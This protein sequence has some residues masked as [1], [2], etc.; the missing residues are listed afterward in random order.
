MRRLTFIVLLMVTGS[1]GAVEESLI[2]SSGTQITE[3]LNS[4]PGQTHPRQVLFAGTGSVEVEDKFF[5]GGCNYSDM[6]YKH[7]SKV[8]VTLKL[9]HPGSKY[10]T[11]GNYEY[12]IPLL[13][14]VW[15]LS[16]QSA[17]PSKSF[18]TS[19]TVV[20]K[21][22]NATNINQLVSSFVVNDYYKVRVTRNGSATSLSQLQTDGVKLEISTK[23]VTNRSYK[24]DNF[25][26]QG[27]YTY[28]SD[29][30][31][32]AN[33]R[34]DVARIAI[35]LDPSY[36]PLVQI[37]GFNSAITTSNVTADEYDLE[38]CFLDKEGQLVPNSNWSTDNTSLVNFNF[39]NLNLKYTRVTL[40]PNNLTYDIPLLYPAGYIVYRVRAVSYD[41][42]GNRVE[43]GWN[44]Q[45]NYGNSGSYN[46]FRVMHHEKSLNWTSSILFAEDGK[47][48]E[49]VTYFDGTQRER[50]SVSINNTNHIALFTE[51]MYDFEGRKAISTLPAPK[52]FN[53]P[54]YLYGPGGSQQKLY[55]ISRP[56]NLIKFQPGFN[57]NDNNK[58][59]KETDFNKNPPSGCNLLASS[60]MSFNT[61][62][63]QY[64]SA[65]NGLH[66]N[67]A[68]PNRYLNNWVPNA[69]KYPYLQTK[70]TT[71]GTNRVLFQTGVGDAHKLASNHETRF[72]Y[73]NVNS[74]QELDRLFGTEVGN[75]LFYNKTYTEDPNGQTSVTYQDAKGKTIAT[76][77]IGDKPASLEGVNSGVPGN[78][79]D[80]ISLGRLNYEFISNDNVDRDYERMKI[81]GSASHFVPVNNE[82]INFE[83]NF[84]TSGFQQGLCPPT[85][86]C[87]DCYYDIDYKMM[88][89]CGNMVFNHKKSNYTLGSNQ[90]VINWACDNNTPSPLPGVT[91][92]FTASGLSKGMYQI[93]AK[94]S[95]P[96][97]F[98]DLYTRKYLDEMEACSTYSIESFMSKHIDAIDP[99]TCISSCEKCEELK[100]TWPTDFKARIR[101]QLKP[102]EDGQFAN[103]PSGFTAF[104]ET[105]A[106]NDYTK[107][108]DRCKKLCDGKYYAECNAYRSQML[109]DVNPG[110]QY[111]LKILSTGKYSAGNPSTDVCVAYAIVNNSKFIK[112]DGTKYKDIDDVIQNWKMEWGDKL[113]EYHPEYCYY[114]KCISNENANIAFEKAMENAKTFDCDVLTNNNW[115]TNSL[116]SKLTQF[117]SG[118]QSQYNSFKFFS[119]SSTMTARSLEEWAFILAFASYGPEIL[120]TKTNDPNAKNTLGNYYD[121]VNNGRCPLDGYCDQDKALYWFH[122]KN[123]LRNLRDVYKNKEMHPTSSSY[124]SSAL[125]SSCVRNEFINC[126]TAT[127]TSTNS[128]VTILNTHKDLFDGLYNS[129]NS[130]CTQHNT[131]NILYFHTNQTGG[132]ITFKGNLFNNKKR[133]FPDWETQANSFIQKVE[134][135]TKSNSYTGNQTNPEQRDL[136]NTQD[137]LMQVVSEDGK[138][139]MCKGQSLGWINELEKCLLNKI[140]LP[141]GFSLTQ[142]K[143]EIRENL[144]KVC[145]VHC[146]EEGFR[147]GTKTLDPNKS[148]EWVEIKI[149]KNTSSEQT[150][151][152]IYSFQ[153]VINKYTG[154]STDPLCSTDPI[155]LPRFE[156]GKN[157]SPYQDFQY[158]HNAPRKES[159]ECDQIRLWKSKFDAT[160]GTS[161]FNYMKSVDASF[162][163][164]EAQLNQLVQGCN[165]VSVK[166]RFFDQAPIVLPQAFMCKKFITC[167]EIALLKDGFNKKYTGYNWGGT[168]ERSTLY[169]NTLAGYFNT[170]KGMN[171]TYYDYKMFEK[172]CEGCIASDFV[173]RRSNL[174]GIYNSYIANHPNFPNW[175]QDNLKLLAAYFNGKSDHKGVPL[176]V[177]N[178]LAMIKL[179][180]DNLI[181]TDKKIPCC[182]T[183]YYYQ[184][185]AKY[186][187]KANQSQYRYHEFLKSFINVKGKYSLSLLDYTAILKN[188]GNI[189]LANAYNCCDLRLKIKEHDRLI[190][191]NQTTESRTAYLN[192]VFGQSKQASD[193]NSELTFCANGP[194]QCL[195]IVTATCPSD[196]TTVINTY[197]TYL[198]GNSTFEIDWDNIDQTLL[199]A[200][201]LALGKPITAAYF[202]MLYKNPKCDRNKCQIIIHYFNYW[203]VYIKG[204]G[205]TTNIKLS[206][207]EEML[208]Y[209][210]AKTLIEDKDVIFNTLSTS[211]LA[212]TPAAFPI[213]NQYKDIYTTHYKNYLIANPSFVFDWVTPSNSSAFITYVN[214]Q[215][216]GTGVSITA[217]EFKLLFT[218]PRL[219]KCIINECDEVSYFLTKYKAKKGYTTFIPPSSLNEMT[220]YIS[221]RIYRNVTYTEVAS[222]AGLNLCTMYAPIYDAYIDYLNSLLNTNFQMDWTNVSG[223]LI[224]ALNASTTLSS[225]SIVIK[226]SDLSIVFHDFRYQ[227]YVTDPCAELEFYFNKFLR[228]KGITKTEFSPKNVSE[229]FVYLNKFYGGPPKTDAYWT[230]KLK[231]CEIIDFCADVFSKIT[232]AYSTYHDANTNFE[233]DWDNLV[234]VSPSP[235]QQ[236]FLAFIQN[237][238]LNGTLDGE[239][240][241]IAFNNTFCFNKFQCELIKHYY[242]VY[243]NDPKYGSGQF[244]NPPNASLDG[245]W[246]FMNS[247]FNENLSFKEWVKKVRDCDNTDINDY[248][249]DC[250]KERFCAIELLSLNETLLKESLFNMDNTLIDNNHLNTL[251]ACANKS[252][253]MD[254]WRLLFTLCDFNDDCFDKEVFTK[255]YANNSVNQFSVTKC[256]LKDYILALNGQTM[257]VDRKLCF[258]MD[259]LKRCKLDVYL[260]MTA[261]SCTAVAS[262]VK[263]YLCTIDPDLYIQTTMVTDPNGLPIPSYDFNKG[264]YLEDLC[265]SLNG[266]FQTTLSICDYEMILESCQ[267]C[268]YA[269]YFEYLNYDF[270][271]G[272][273]YKTSYVNEP[274]YYPYTTT[275]SSW[276]SPITNMNRTLTNICN[277]DLVCSKFFNYYILNGSNKPANYTIRPVNPSMTSN[278]MT[279]YGIM[280]FYQD[281]CSADCSYLLD[282]PDG[283]IDPDPDDDPIDPSGPKPCD[284]SDCITYQNAYNKA[285]NDYITDGGD[286]SA[287]FDMW[288]EYVY[289]NM[290]YEIFPGDVYMTMEELKLKLLCCGIDI[291][292]LDCGELTSY[293]NTFVQNKASIYATFPNA[294]DDK[295]LL[296]QY[297]NDKFGLNETL[298]FWLAKIRDHCHLLP[299]NSYVPC[300]AIIS[301]LYEESHGLTT[302]SIY[303]RF[304]GILGSGA[305]PSLND[306]MARI[307]ACVSCTDFLNYFKTSKA[308]RGV[309]IQYYQSK[310]NRRVVDIDKVFRYFVRWFGCEISEA[311]ITAYLA[312][313]ESDPN[314]KP[315]APP[316]PNSGSSSSMAMTAAP[317]I[318]MGAPLNSQNSSLPLNSAK[319][320]NLLNLEKRSILRESMLSKPLSNNSIRKA[321]V[322]KS[323]NTDR[324]S[325]AIT[326][327]TSNASANSS[328]DYEYMN[329]LPQLVSSPIPMGQESPG[330]SSGT[331][332]CM[333]EY[334]NLI[335]DF[336]IEDYKCCNVCDKRLYEKMK[337]KKPKE[338]DPCDYMMALAITNARNE[339]ENVFKELATAF[340]KKYIQKCI[341]NANISIT[342]NASDQEHHYTLYYYGQDGN[343]V[344]TVPPAGVKKFTTAAQ[345]SAVNSNRA[346]GSYFAPDHT[347]LTKYWYNQAN[348]VVRQTTPDAGQS[349]F[350]YD[351]LGR[352]ILSQNEKQAPDRCSYTKYDKL[353]RIIES[354]E[355]WE[356][357]TN[358]CAQNNILFTSQIYES[359]AMSGGCYLSSKNLHLMNYCNFERYLE[360]NVQPRK[361]VVRTYYDKMPT[362]IS[363]AGVFAENTSKRVVATTLDEMDS[364]KDPTT[365][366][367]ALFYSYDILG[368]V[369]RLFTQTTNPTVSVQHRLKKMD[370]E[371]DVQS[372]KV[373]KV[374]Y[375]KD[376]PDQYIHKYEYDA[377]NRIIAAKTS[378]DDY[379]Y[380]TEA[381]YKY[382]L[383]G[384]LARTQM[385]ERLVQGLDY[386]YTIHGWL[387]SVNGSSLNHYQ[388]P[389]NDGSDNLMVTTAITV[390]AGNTNVASDAVAFS[391]DYYNTGATTMDYN[392]IVGNANIKNQAGARNLFNGNIGHMTTSQYAFNTTAN[393]S[394]LVFNYTYDQLNRLVG[395]DASKGP[396]AT[397]Q[398]A[399]NDYME[400]VKYDP[401]GNIMNY[402]RNMDGATSATTS[403]MDNLK[404]Q[405]YYY[406]AGSSTKTPYDPATK[407][408]A[409]GDRI[410]NQL[411]QVQDAVG[412]T[413]F[414]KDIETQSNTDNYLYDKIGNLI[415]D[416]QE[417]MDITWTP[418]GKIDNI[419]IDQANKKQL[420]V[421][422][423]DPMGNRILKI[424]HNG[425]TTPVATPLYTYYSRDAQGNTIAI[426]NRKTEQVFNGDGYT[427]TYPEGLSE[428]HIY[429]SSRLGIKRPKRH[430]T[431]RYGSTMSPHTPAAGEYNFT[432]IGVSLDQMCINGYTPNFA[433]ACANPIASN[434][435]EY[436]Y[437]EPV[438]TAA[439]P[440]YAWIPRA[441]WT[442]QFSS[443]S[444][445]ELPN[446]LG[447]VLAT[448]KDE[449]KYTTASLGWGFPTYYPPRP[450]VL[451][452]TDYYPFGMPM[453]NRTYSLS[454]GSKYRFG[455]NTQEKDDEVYG[456]GNLMSAKYWE[457]DAR[458]GR[459][460]N[461]DPITYTWQSP[462]SVNND[463]PIVF[464]DPLGLF[465]TRKEA[466]AYKKE[467]D[468][469][470][471]IKE[472]KDGLFHINDKKNGRSYVRDESTDNIPNLIGRGEDGVIK[473]AL[474]T[475]EKKSSPSS[476]AFTAGIETF[477]GAKNQD[478]WTISHKA[479]KALSDA[480]VEMQTRVLKQGLS[481]ASKSVAKH[482][483]IIGHIL[484]AKEVI[485]GIQADGNALG[486]NTAIEVAGVAGGAGGAWAGASMG[487]MIGTA[488]CPGVGTVVGGVVGGVLGSWGGEEATEAITRKAL[489]E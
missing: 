217:N 120:V 458:I 173:E 34:K 111:G 367:S 242:D 48:K 485:D 319:E 194:G 373:N 60:P 394:T 10:N 434:Y 298:D 365:F 461:R 321:N 65:N 170:Y 337:F 200:I 264:A 408:F 363:P 432:G 258:D 83:M 114:E 195:P 4:A 471:K 476:G 132:T 457:Y 2:P 9:L 61:G 467:H 454:T 354:G 54:Y 24:I 383:H 456:E 160:G 75:R 193:Y 424:V 360:S 455:Y 481:S 169:Q 407:T 340:K 43:G 320:L 256:N 358:A 388:E 209:I 70:Y 28:V 6:F 171:L 257:G 241:R 442:N 287:D 215:M 463:N 488:I 212:N 480:G 237:E 89:N 115:S 139:E 231:T 51:T 188:C 327:E 207:I 117:G 7:S 228:Y 88:D 220:Q 219:R 49:A 68:F 374:Y 90:P 235:D 376:S 119:T 344:M 41:Q 214:T 465:G 221:D 67:T 263:T 317:T 274:G 182:V 332:N 72:H 314:F 392:S 148:S 84:S 201:A 410:T 292:D 142:L 187:I 162:S 399:M 384:P 316:M 304:S 318:S 469:K 140:T 416:K 328:K 250:E 74:Q 39:S 245:F 11:T 165:D 336:N 296:R 311:A 352:L 36:Q 104:V 168:P 97:K 157:N 152:G 435:A 310:S 57:L 190:K 313:L 380:N 330:S 253:T 58:Y 421:F 218:S 3:P 297:L 350:V 364:D 305:K 277:Q 369:K 199:N 126:G 415:K 52:L 357:L 161:F 100:A 479:N 124:P 295:D 163:I 236:A 452:A 233:I 91:H 213:C 333:N 343:L 176:S 47:K 154:S 205:S 94:V 144:E 308:F 192:R 294:T 398:T 401:N 204:Y 180:C 262:A 151:S 137:D 420:I 44:Y 375:Q 31:T 338:T 191:D 368:N 438:T 335:K 196:F 135:M 81:T 466:R 464:T 285:V 406:P 387:K 370:Y 181:G 107:L 422:K 206:E 397:S 315:M 483:P 389:G 78:T 13:I 393:P 110:G 446:H 73:T 436:D 443:L 255:R 98:A 411:A 80:Y 224:A 156:A 267:P 342:A 69:N 16:N 289:W 225:K 197:I 130:N 348:Q 21:D 402:F 405:Y 143:A 125:A 391:L 8:E 172:D 451:N 474:I 284:N 222:C 53:T 266:T 129:T 149:F 87:I 268:C 426:F 179:L 269:D 33:D 433:Y 244:L 359:G 283:G 251:N 112:P 487:A 307:R 96:E 272:Y 341:D 484:D 347:H 230:E 291:H 178:S 158:I 122:Y 223:S 23:I 42:L 246:Q 427:T 288:W 64:Y 334:S 429:G 63:S 15:D 306:I 46:V 238:T 453:P 159:C 290:I 329:E 145:R 92:S 17:T 448:I 280:E 353:N 243:K 276:W 22:P 146:G 40:K 105:T 95:V 430:L 1:L 134:T 106:Q 300:L 249:I 303:D 312:D 362:G 275:Y 208:D 113:L 309:L 355:L 326:P 123:L 164:T 346:A 29:N 66:Y 444:E 417:N 202:K 99:F 390:Q 240:I 468:I 27:E 216:A 234:S 62:S 155:S 293:Y 400:K 150:I 270:L 14:E 386:V 259:L 254:D 437:Y 404:Y 226:A 133:V 441:K 323:L 25:L 239:D 286:K 447:N 322:F 108:Q 282:D 428:Y 26:P 198:G 101:K 459:R 229:L 301:Y 203:K 412:T 118:F 473:S 460:W 366:S 38:W 248:I 50:Q 32:Y 409:S 385:G 324:A 379:L 210:S 12:S 419:V 85:N 247:K 183:D 93:T 271:K 372:G 102:L 279:S 19:L 128:N 116:L 45:F 331:S 56:S 356:N 20:Y 189:D 153:D 71:D 109:S 175:K 418:S 136:D 55:D 470:G 339:R 141:S 478:L 35:N 414:D 482:A 371:F 273:Y 351:E 211:C 440:G 382:Y 174:Q 167:F 425:S 431:T 299:L 59:F 489:K 302:Q 261:V 381:T 396:S 79:S 445:Y 449:Q 37:C 413:T 349:W 177:P 477:G 325:Q 462:Y 345:F 121:N 131:A 127:Q 5:G 138:R 281:T 252:Y 403:N 185:I 86:G 361:Y 76:A 260:N 147:F 423:Y 486:A 278:L 395:M 265:N 82:N 378:F 166:C 103:D 439:A 184:Y 30:S 475:G 377:E 227:C 18:P 450:I 232:L 77:L 186:P 472:G